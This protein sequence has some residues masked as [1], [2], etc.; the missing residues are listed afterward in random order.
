[1]N[2]KRKLL[3]IMFPGWGVSKDAWND[4]FISEI[5][6]IGKVYFY[7]PAYYSGYMGLTKK[8]I[9]VDTVCDKI[10]NDTKGFDIIPIGHSVGAYFVYRFCQKYAGVCLFGVIIDGMFVTYTPKYPKEKYIRT[11]KKYTKYTNKDIIKFINKSETDTLFKI[12]FFNIAKYSDR[13]IRTGKFN[14]PMIAFYNFDSNC[15]D[16]INKSRTNDIEW[17]RRNN[18][19]KDFKIITFLDKTHFP[20]YIDDSRS[21]ILFWIKEMVVRKKING[22]K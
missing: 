3:F 2:N 21:E 5:K 10:Y 4:V 6:K 18:K 1:M 8:D 20:H 19:S 17:I 14:T 9:D 11:M 13:I 16:G 12:C 22:T 7:E 15:K